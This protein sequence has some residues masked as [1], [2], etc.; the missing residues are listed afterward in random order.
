MT[1]FRIRKLNCVGG[2]SADC[3]TAALAHDSG[4]KHFVGGRVG[5]SDAGSHDRDRSAACLKSGLMCSLVNSMSKPG[6]DRHA[7]LR[8][9]CSETAGD[10]DPVF[11]G[12]TGA[13]DGE[14][15]LI[16]FQY[17]PSYE[18]ERRAIEYR[19]EGSRDTTCPA[20]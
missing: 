4:A 3:E 13:D 2:V 5:C 15:G 6:H 20:R 19:P 10:P 9:L 8:K 16:R 12:A 18:E 17:L 1:T 11:R 7:T 14:R